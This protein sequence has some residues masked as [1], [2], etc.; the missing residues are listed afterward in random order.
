MRKTAGVVVAGG[1]QRILYVLRGGVAW[2]GVAWRLL[3]SVCPRGQPCIAGS[4]SGDTGVFQTL[5]HDGGPET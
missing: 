5:T 4:R 1:T 2:R 3:P